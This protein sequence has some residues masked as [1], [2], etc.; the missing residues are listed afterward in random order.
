MSASSK[1]V[2]IMLNDQ[3]A[4]DLAE[5]RKHIRKNGSTGRLSEAIRFALRK[6][7]DA[8]ESRSI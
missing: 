1:R 4:D 7:A 3:C 6:T 2:H 8:L 5:I